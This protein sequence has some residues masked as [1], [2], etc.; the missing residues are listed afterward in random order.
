MLRYASGSEG[1]A[2]CRLSLKDN[3]PV[4]MLYSFLHD[5]AIHELVHKYVPRQLPADRMGRV[6]DY[7]RERPVKW[8][9]F[10]EMEHCV[11]VQ[12]DPREIPQGFRAAVPDP[13]HD[14]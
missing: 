14:Q 11:Q 12:A 1:S 5:M 10:G 8:L 13:Q 2:S 4:A 6:A 9:L 3:S 7:H